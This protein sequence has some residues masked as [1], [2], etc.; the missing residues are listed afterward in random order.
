MFQKTM[1]YVQDAILMD[2][3]R[4]LVVQQSLRF[5]VDHKEIVFE[6]LHF[7]N[8]R[9]RNF[10]L[11]P[12]IAKRFRVFFQ[13]INLDDRIHRNWTFIEKKKPHPPAG[14]Q[15]PQLTKK[16]RTFICS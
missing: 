11:R 2:L 4:L 9:A 10:E 8:L 6:P 3:H 15:G 5:L 14:G 13:F 1:W 12:W 16:T 7:Y